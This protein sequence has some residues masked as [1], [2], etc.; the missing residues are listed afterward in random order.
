MVPIANIIILYRHLHT[1]K[2]NG[3]IFFIPFHLEFGLPV[4]PLLTWLLYYYKL[5]LHDT[6]LEGILHLSVFIMLCGGFLGILAQY[7]LWRF[8]F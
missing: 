7:D 8:L 2:E 3:V 1:L 5:Y 6:T 4:H